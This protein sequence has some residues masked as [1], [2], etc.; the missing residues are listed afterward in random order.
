MTTNAQPSRDPAN[1][2]GD[3]PG[4]MR[5][6]LAKFLQSSIDDMLPAKI[7]AYDR[8]TNRATVKPLIA[9]MTTAGE[10][11]SRNQLVSIPVINI[12]GGGHI[13]SFNFS[14]NDLGWIKANDRDISDFL[15]NYSEA[16]PSTKRI[17]D[18][19]NGVFIP[20]VMTGYTIAGE[21]AGNAVLQSLDGTVKVSLSSNKL[22]LLAPTVDINGNSINIEGDTNV[23]IAAP[24]IDIIGDT[25]VNVQAPTVSITANTA[26]NLIS[27]TIINLTSLVISAATG[28]ITASD[29]ATSVIASLNAHG[30]L[31]G[32]FVDAE[33][34]AI[35]GKSGVPS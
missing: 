3:M 35:T 2:S 14:P 18:F 32:T 13:L 5:E 20:D 29:F 27:T 6:V 23:M 21:D 28:V 24:T 9:M 26:L 22:T 8:D 19:N 25:N 10:A 7:V 16:V 33:A 17:H 4:G 31:P 34:R 1:S 30:H 11:I 12:G 15:K